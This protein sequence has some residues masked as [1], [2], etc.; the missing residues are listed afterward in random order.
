MIHGEPQ[1]TLGSPRD[2]APASR[3]EALD[4]VETAGLLAFQQSTTSRAPTTPYFALTVE[5]AEQLHGRGV[6][7]VCA[8]DDRSVGIPVR[9]IY[10]PIAWRYCWPEASEPDFGHR[11]LAHLSQLGRHSEAAGEKASLWRTL[12]NA[13]LEGYF[14]H[15]LRRHGFDPMW[16]SD[17]RDDGDR[18]YKGLSLAQA[19]YLVW[20]S[21]REGAAVFLRT[22]EDSEEAREAMMV[23]MKRRAKWLETRPELGATFLPLSNARQSLLLSV[24][25]DHVARIGTRYWLAPPAERGL[26]IE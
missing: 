12:A 11:A 2:P 20:A 1:P 8:D 10:D 4:L 19:R 25:L 5:L 24:F 6:I 21:V 9:A 23:E 14:A 22:G 16:A 17:I 13:E 15:L 3:L 26:I 7:A 18:W